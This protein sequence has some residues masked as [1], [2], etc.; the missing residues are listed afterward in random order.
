MKILM[1]GSQESLDKFQ[2]AIHYSVLFVFQSPDVK[3]KIVIA[4]LFRWK[5]YA[6]ITSKIPE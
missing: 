4:R 2:M 6:T 3:I 1:N 5:N